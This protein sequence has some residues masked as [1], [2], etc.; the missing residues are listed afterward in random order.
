MKHIGIIKDIF[1]LS[2]IN[3]YWNSMDSY[4]QVF[5][6]YIDKNINENNY[7]EILFDNNTICDSFIND[8][9]I[10]DKMFSYVLRCVKNKIE[11]IDAKIPQDR[12]KI[13]VEKGYISINNDNIRKMLKNN[14]YEEIVLLINKQK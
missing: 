6:N 8:N 11:N 5:V 1:T 14:F 9:E 3:C 13:L 10:S 12:V 7:K 4:N 2:N